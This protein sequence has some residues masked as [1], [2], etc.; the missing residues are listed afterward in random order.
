VTAVQLSPAGLNDL[1]ENPCQ[2]SR[3]SDGDD[4]WADFLRPELFS[5]DKKFTEIVG[6]TST[7]FSSPRDVV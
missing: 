5:S 1:E 6:R 3:L 2:L 4:G 7:I